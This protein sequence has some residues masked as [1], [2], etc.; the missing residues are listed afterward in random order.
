MLF[1]RQCHSDM[2][3]RTPMSSTEEL[4]HCK[5]QVGER[6]ISFLFRNVY[7]AD[8]F[9]TESIHFIVFIIFYAVFNVWSYPS[10][11]VLKLLFVANV[12]WGS[13]WQETRLN[14]SLSTMRL[15]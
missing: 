5:S 13:L 11:A 10:V 12:V 9:V 1:A 2:L 15:V 3:D 8:V 6:T 4:L 14:V 7:S